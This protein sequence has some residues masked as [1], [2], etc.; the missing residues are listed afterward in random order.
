MMKGKDLIFDDKSNSFAQ[1]SDSCVTKNLLAHTTTT[2]LV[3]TTDAR[4]PAN[5]ARSRHRG[6][7]KH[8]SSS[9][10]CS[11]GS[12]SSHKVGMI[13]WLM[14]LPMM[15]VVVVQGRPGTGLGAAE[16]RWTCTEGRVSPGGV[17]GGDDNDRNDVDANSTHGDHTRRASVFRRK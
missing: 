5:S 10:R 12:R 7:E 4:D 1:C 9:S 6:R 2:M 16:L 8:R 3:V 11:Q 17:D 13:I 14:T 15:T